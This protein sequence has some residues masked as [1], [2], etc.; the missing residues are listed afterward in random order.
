MR[1]ID[2]NPTVQSSEYQVKEITALSNVVWSV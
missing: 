1:N 2:L